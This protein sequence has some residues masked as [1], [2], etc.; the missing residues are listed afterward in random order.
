MPSVLTVGRGT[1]GRYSMGDEKFFQAGEG[2]RRLRGAR[3]RGAPIL[4]RIR[5]TQDTIGPVA[6]GHPWVYMEGLAAPSE[7]PEPGTLAL[8]VDGRDKPVAFAISDRGEVAA[9]ILGRTPETLERL[10]PRRIQD[11]AAGRAGLLPPETE[12]WRVVN[13]EGDGLPGVV[14]DRYGPVAVLRLYAACWEP[15]LDLL[16]A[17]I[18]K[19]PGVGTILRRFGV[20]RVDGREG[21]ERLW[22]P[23]VAEPLVVKE[24]GL[25]FLVRPSE[26]QKTGLFLD[27]REHRRWIRERAAGRTVLDLFAYTGGFSVYAA[28]GG[29]KRVC[30]VDASAP[31]LADARE[32]FTLN[33]LDPGAHAFVVTD[34]FTWAPEGGQDLVIC[35]PPSLTH[36]Q[37]SDAAARNAYRDLAA[38]CGPW[39]G[40][41]GLLATASCTARLSMDR[42]E[43]SVREGLRKTGRWSWLWR[44]AEPPDH[45]TALDH[46]EGR[47]LKFAVLRR[48]T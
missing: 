38:R 19:L 37:R 8:L 9:R 47:Y 36:G 14:V 2:G 46:P 43:Q 45:P 26:G 21:V 48:L 12:A 27:Q 25:R 18:A 34:A 39:V 16:V 15:H 33:G 22:G 24:S 28:A 5:L 29:A 40:S 7:L 20:R 4:A 30:T 23:P 42:W 41:G 11:A 17:A 1:P 13:G 35:D 3:P 10:L 31:A 32:N 6:R 44:A